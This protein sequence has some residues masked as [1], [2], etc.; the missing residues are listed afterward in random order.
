VQDFT[1]LL[2]QLGGSNLTAAQIHA[3]RQ[4]KNQTHA[5][6]LPKTV[7]IDLRYETIV[8]G[9]STL[10]IYRDVYE[11]GT[12]TL[13][14]AKRILAAQGVDYDGLSDQEKSNLND[15]LD[16]MN[17]DPRGK[18]ISTDSIPP[19]KHGVPA[20]K[21]A[22]SKKGK[23]TYHIKGKKEA[24]VTIAALQGKGY[25]DPVDLGTGAAEKVRN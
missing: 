24:D 14:N 10:H 7:P 3:F 5:I 12:N 25:P 8:T 16:A 18:P 20:D 17:R 23:V 6:K 13:A 19:S 4:H 11:R 21:I 1:V 22:R 2:S 15:A 9:D